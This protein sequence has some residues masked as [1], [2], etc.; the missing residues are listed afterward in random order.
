[1]TILCIETGGENCSVALFREKEAIA[2]RENYQ[3]EHSR[4]LSVL[5]DEVVKSSNLK[6]NDIDAVAIGKGPGS[7]TGLRIGVATAKGICYGISKPLIAIDSLLSL[8]SM[9][10]RED[11]NAVYCPM[12]DARR[13]EV[14]TAM[15]DASLNRLSETQAVILTESSFWEILDRQ[16]VYFFGS[17][18]EKFKKTVN[19]PNAIFIDV[20]NSAKGLVKPAIEAFE[21]NRFENLAYFEP[22]YLKDFVVTTQKKNILKIN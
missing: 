7:Y 11:K 12:I 20:K 17:G 4:L 15:F 22:F 5:I 16:K 18:A 13:Q 8:T 3:R 1:M 10:S 14:Y 6:Y 21:S 9:C 2:I 19:N